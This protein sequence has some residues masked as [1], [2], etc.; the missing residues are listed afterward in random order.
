MSLMVIPSY[1][2][3]SNFCIHA[4]VPVPVH[5]HAPWIK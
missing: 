5:L 1:E 4:T 3:I 2:Y